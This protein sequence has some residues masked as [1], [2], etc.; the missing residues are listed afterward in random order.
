MIFQ[1]CELCGENFK[2]EN[3]GVTIVLTL[4][5]FGFVSRMKLFG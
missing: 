5:A 2:S 3:P 4:Y 1:K